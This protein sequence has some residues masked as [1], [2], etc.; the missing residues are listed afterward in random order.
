MGLPV[1][2]HEPYV[3][4]YRQ[5]IGNREVV[6]P[7]ASGQEV[8]YD[9]IDVICPPIKWKPPS[10]LMSKLQ[11]ME[12]GDWRKM[13]IADKKQLYRLNFCQTLKEVEAPSYTFR[14]VLGATL[15]A[16][17]PP[18]LA[19]V[20]LK[21]TVFPPP[22][23][24]YSDQAKKQL[25]RFMIDSRAEPMDGISTKWDYEKNQWKEKPFFLMRK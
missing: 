14:R 9:R 1:H 20:A 17:C 2:A 16:L 3:P 4:W 25:V 6:G 12:K 13:S 22:I 8:Y 18:I 5:K 23:E 21:L 19:F 7:S 11:A 10:E 15:L 24:A